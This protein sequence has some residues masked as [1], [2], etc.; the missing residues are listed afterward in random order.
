[1]ANDDTYNEDETPSDDT[2]IRALRKKADSADVAARER[3][4]AR[5]EVLF[6]RAGVDPSTP[7]GKLLFQ[8][9]NG[10]E[11][12]DLKQQATSVGYQ[13]GAATDT[14]PATQE[15]TYEQ[16]ET[17]Q[18]QFRTQ[19]AAGTPAGQTLEHPEAHPVDVAFDEFFRERQAGIPREEAALAVVDRLIV[20]GAK[21][22]KRVIFDPDKYREEARRYEQPLR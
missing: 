14:P 15:R 7:L 3:D 20:A 12:D 5:R 8:T 21:G 17:T 22:D 19:M 1:M 6:L 9:Y 4:E 10:S 16:D 13:F 2:N 18:Q 11:V